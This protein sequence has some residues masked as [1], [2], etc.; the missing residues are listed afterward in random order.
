MSMPCW[1]SRLVRMTRRTKL[2]VVGVGNELHGDDAAGVAVVRALREAASADQGLLIL[3]AGQAPENQIGP[4]LRFR[5]DV[6]VFVDAA[7]MGEVPGT[8]R[9]VSWQDADGMGASTHTLSPEVLAQ[10]LIDELGCEVYLLGIQPTSLAFGAS[11]SPVVAEAVRDV[12]RLLADDTAPASR[13][14]RRRGSL[15]Y[16]TGE[17]LAKQICLYCGYCA[18]YCPYEVL[19]QEEI[20]EVTHVEG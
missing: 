18:S 14:V 6:I 13:D 1:Q 17:N 16:G 3:E 7:D 12:A 5:P 8:V 10:F 2:A 20:G 4:L 9:W 19:K 15:L 11:L